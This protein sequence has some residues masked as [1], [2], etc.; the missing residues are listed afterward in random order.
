[1]ATVSSDNYNSRK[2]SEELQLLAEVHVLA[3]HGSVQ[4]G[5]PIN[6]VVL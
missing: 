5:N 4:V 1:M 6:V 3:R 2:E